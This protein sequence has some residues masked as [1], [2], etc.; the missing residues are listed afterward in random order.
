MLVV[1]TFDLDEYVFAALRGGA[2][3]FLPK[4]VEPTSWSTRSGWS[5]GA[6]GWSPPR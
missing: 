5:P 4:D 6:T 2:S 3:G 1:T